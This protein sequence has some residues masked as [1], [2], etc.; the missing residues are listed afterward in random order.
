MLSRQADI[1]QTGHHQA[2][3]SFADAEPVHSVPG[4]VR[5][6]AALLKSSPVI[7]DRFRNLLLTLPGIHDVSVNGRCSTATIGYDCAKWSAASL[8]IYVAGLDEKILKGAALSVDSEESH[9][10]S[11]TGFT[12]CLSSS[13]L[14]VGLI[15]DTL[16]AWPALL[17][18]ALPMLV[19]ARRALFDQQRLTLDVLDTSAGSVF[20]AQGFLPMAQFVVWTVN[21]SD[22]LRDRTGQ[23]WPV[24]KRVRQ[25]AAPVDREVATGQ[26]VPQDAI[27]VQ[28]TEYRLKKFTQACALPPRGETRIEHYGRKWADPWV[29]LSFLASGTA[30]GIGAGLQGAAAPLIIDY[31][32]VRLAAPTAVLS[33]MHRAAALGIL[34]KHGRAMERLAHVDTIVLDKTKTLTAGLFEHR[35]N[36]HAGVARDAGQF[37]QDGLSSVC[38]AVEGEVRGLPAYRDR[39]QAEAGSVLTELRRCKIQRIVLLSGDSHA[40]VKRTADALGIEEYHGDMLP[41]DKAMMIQELK[42]TGHTVAMVGDGTND[43]PV[44]LASDVGIAVAGSTPLARQ[45]ADIELRAE[46][47][48]PLCTALALSREAKG[49]IEQSWDIVSIP[50]TI[51]LALTACGVLGPL[52]A[53]ILGNGSAIAATL[54]G[55]RPLLSGCPI[56]RNRSVRT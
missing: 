27:E 41:R 15:A 36:G 48:R 47:L 1:A 8:S 6:R 11:E 21:L 24:A 13:G 49:L 56:S 46:G 30:A 18:S 22:Y 35:I 31:G 2:V 29:P 12:L 28:P 54:N 40:M 16:L 14:A 4:R 19:R 17:L 44:F 37:G 43:A 20:I 25:E 55:L 10:L 51:A 9:Q 7:R 42:R 32:G 33:V 45:H 53:A 52:G 38:V 5:I 26:P 34:F 39:L 50:N 3:R 23:S